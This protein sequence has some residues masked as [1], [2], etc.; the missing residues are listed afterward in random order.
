MSFYK[1]RKKSKEI[2]DLQTIELEPFFDYRGEIRTLFDQDDW[3][4]TFVED[5]VSISHKN[6]LRGLHGDDNTHK[7]ISCLGGSFF[8]AVADARIDSK[9]FGNI[10]T[11]IL[12]DS[13]PKLIFVPAGC[14]NGH[15]SLTDR[16][17]FW[18]K[19]SEKY[20]E[21]EKQVTCMWN[22]EKLNI[23]WPCQKPILSERDKNGTKFKGI[24]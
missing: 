20:K 24:K 1:T 2:K 14:L 17:V 12:D 4:Q 11:F 19:W 18:Y 23:P 10:E 6:V 16:C 13:N 7:L 21:P 9:T 15:L 22:D 8:L 5:K 3:E